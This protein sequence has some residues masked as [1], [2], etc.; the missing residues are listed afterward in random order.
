MSEAND[1]TL[2]QR[3][4]DTLQ[5][6]ADRKASRQS[7]R[8]ERELN[9]KERKRLLRGGKDS[10]A[11][12]ASFPE[13]APIELDRLRVR[14][15]HYAFLI[16]WMLIAFLG[17]RL[18]YMTFDYQ[19]DFFS[20][21]SILIIFAS[22]M[23]M[24][25]CF[26]SAKSHSQ[27]YDTHIVSVFEY[28]LRRGKNRFIY[29]SV[30]DPVDYSIR[31]TVELQEIIDV[32][33]GDIEGGVSSVGSAGNRSTQDN[34]VGSES[35][36]KNEK[37]GVDSESVVTSA[38]RRV[39]TENEA[40]GSD[41]KSYP[42]DEDESSPRFGGVIDDSN[43]AEALEAYKSE[44]SK[45][46]YAQ[47]MNDESSS[48]VAG[49]EHTTKN[50]EKRVESDDNVATEKIAEPKS[51]MPEQSMFDSQAIVVKPAST[52][53]DKYKNNFAAPRNK[54][55][56]IPIEEIDCVIIGNQSESVRDVDFLEKNSKIREM[57]ISDRSQLI[58]F[59]SA[60]IFGAIAASGLA[61][62]I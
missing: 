56:T 38:S 44:Y 50:A 4:A 24:V 10:T 32:P 17:S 59:V 15:V 28:M 30:H 6:R 14:P 62:V 2:T 45:P 55:F 43:A 5:K 42:A 48:A 51:T 27:D 58:A 57:L 36:K 33:T 52:L 21:F 31:G 53:T 16:A 23:F 37:S 29:R 39:D 41:L 35:D 3:L 25:F 47:F 13:P 26:R 60:Y 19:I 34:E 54:S 7:S 49:D 9:K 1:Y 11:E 20:D 8:S 18:V 40:D 12:D 22:T 46:F 61:F